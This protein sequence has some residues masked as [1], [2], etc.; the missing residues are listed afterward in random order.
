V[1][2]D[3][4]SIS[5]TEEVI[6][7]EAPPDVDLDL[8][9]MEDDGE[10]SM[11]TMVTKGRH[12]KMARQLRDIVTR[13]KGLTGLLGEWIDVV[14][15]GG[16]PGS[17]A[18]TCTTAMQ[19]RFTQQGIACEG[20]D[21]CGFV[22]LTGPCRFCKEVG[23]KRGCLDVP[24]ALQLALLYAAIERSIERI[25]ASRNYLD[26]RV[27]IVIVGG[28]SAMADPLLVN[29]SFVSIWLQQYIKGIVRSESSSAKTNGSRRRT[30]LRRE[31]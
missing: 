6:P 13:S 29:Q 25:M 22:A 15:I 24:Q 17:G 4:V 19:V 27:G 12:K 31:I 23:R 16:K 3:G 5:H 30:R 1:G 18:R 8:N 26:E 9:R 2:P 7:A 20:V 21:D 28:P 14:L 10:S 11:W